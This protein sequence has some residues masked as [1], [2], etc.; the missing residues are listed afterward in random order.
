MSLTQEFSPHTDG[1]LVIFRVDIKT[2]PGAGLLGRI[3][4]RAVARNFE[5]AVR[6]LHALIARRPDHQRDLRADRFVADD[7]GDRI[8]ERLIGASSNGT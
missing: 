5:R 3:M 6:R 1:T 2:V 7:D 8:L 4:R